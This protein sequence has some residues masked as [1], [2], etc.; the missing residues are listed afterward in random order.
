MK[1]PGEE[2][3]LLRDYTVPAI[4]PMVPGEPGSAGLRRHDRFAGVRIY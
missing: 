2:R 4:E 1:D 3:L